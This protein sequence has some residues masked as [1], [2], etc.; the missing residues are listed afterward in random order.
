[1]RIRVKKQIRNEHPRLRL[2]RRITKV[3][4]M[5]FDLDLLRS[6][7]VLLRMF[8]GYLLSPPSP[9]FSFPANGPLNGS[10]TGK[11]GQNSRSGRGAAAPELGR[12][13]QRGGRAKVAALTSNLYASVSF[14]SSIR[15]LHHFFFNESYDSPLCSPSKKPY[16]TQH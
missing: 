6:R 5:K 12:A 2:L 3:K 4:S 11:T 7:H 13:R 1:M 10:K 8:L 9:P 15:L 14:S 16:T